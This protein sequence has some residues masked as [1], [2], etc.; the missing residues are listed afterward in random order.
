M[1]FFFFFEKKY[2]RYVLLYSIRCG[3]PGV[4][5]LHSVAAQTDL[6][7]TAQRSL[8]QNHRKALAVATLVLGYM[9]LQ[10]SILNIVYVSYTNLTLPTIRLV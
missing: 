4:R 6:E 10:F 1:S 9:G 2:T 8:S 5:Q 3:Q 7:L